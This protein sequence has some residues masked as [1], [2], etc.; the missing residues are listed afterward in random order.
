MTIMLRKLTVFTGLLAL[1]LAA[2]PHRE[3][4]AQDLPAAEV[5][6]MSFNIWLGGELVDFSQVAAVIQASGADIVGMQEATG[7]VRV[8][9]DALGWHYASERTQILS[10]F[11]LIDPPGAD[12]H[13]VLAQIAPGQVVAV[14]N[15]HLPSDP[16]GPYQARD[17]APADDV[18]ALET[19]TRLAALQPTLDALAPLVADG[20]PVFLTGDFNTPSHLDWTEAASESRGLPYAL[21]WPVT[22]AAQQAG[23]MD[24]YRAAHPDPVARPGITW[25][26]GY[27]YPRLNDGEMLDRIDL[28][29]AAG[30][31]T[32]LD[33]QIVGPGG[34]PDADI[35]ISPF[36]SDHR[37]VVTHARVTPV[38]PP[39]FVSADR[40]VLTQ[41]DLAVIRYHAPDGE[42]T[43]RIALVPA[44]GDAAA[45]L[46]FLPP[47]EASFFGSV[48]FA[49]HTLAPGAYDVVLLGAD[50]TELS[51]NTFWVLSPDA[52]PQI[53]AETAVYAAGEPVT[54][55][56]DNAPAY[57]WDW[58]GIYSAGD[59][60]LYNGYWAFAYTNAS[61]SGS[62]TFTDAD[63]G[64]AMLPPGEYVARLMHDDGYLVL[65]E[66]TFTVG[67]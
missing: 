63:L 66:T 29:L 41:G 12:G 32:V 40:R 44:G 35:E 25:T 3:G 52:A 20:V 62:Y 27:P 34:S 58:V 17:G 42:G 8:V 16:Y 14:A 53:T 10:R 26:Y 67:E 50:D 19:D 23:F 6:V 1:L 45:P 48:S 31:V 47:Y 61:V 56:W 7:N 21:A 49:T 33:S 59:A 43:D 64:E 51:R 60:D 57:K 13:Y 9:A 46:M 36:P 22:L 15:V 38:V 28:V 55:R 54:V 11:P 5:R 18:L 37:A 4:I 24:T 39:L 30:N 65:A 2:L